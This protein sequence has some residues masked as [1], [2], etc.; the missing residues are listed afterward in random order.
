[1]HAGDIR[2]R[3]VNRANLRN[4]ISQVNGCIKIGFGEISRMLYNT[5]IGGGEILSETLYTLHNVR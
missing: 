1:M 2:P 4:I 5:C 3:G